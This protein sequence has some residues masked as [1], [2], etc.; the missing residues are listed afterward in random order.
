MKHDI[1]IELFPKIA[2]SINLITHQ[3]AADLESLIAQDDLK[4]FLKHIQS[5]GLGVESPE[6]YSNSCKGI[7][8]TLDLPNDTDIQQ[9]STNCKSIW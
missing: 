8:C 4:A 7:Q 9:E 1:P 5:I 6:K 2:A 3:N